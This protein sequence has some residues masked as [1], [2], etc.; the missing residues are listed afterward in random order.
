MKKMIKMIKM[1][2]ILIKNEKNDRSDAYGDGFLLGYGYAVDNFFF[3]EWS[4][5]NVLLCESISLSVP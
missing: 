1:I 5:E 3:E 2:K 4:V